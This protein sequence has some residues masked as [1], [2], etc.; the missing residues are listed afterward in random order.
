MMT[1]MDEWE[2]LIYLHMHGYLKDEEQGGDLQ[3]DPLDDSGT[4]PGGDH[5]Q[6]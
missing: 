4:V 2:Y 6:R 3:I 1:Y 5:G